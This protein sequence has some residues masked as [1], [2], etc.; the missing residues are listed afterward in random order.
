M[1][2]ETQSIIEPRTSKTPL[3]RNVSFTLMWSSTAASGFGDRM[4]MLAAAALLGISVTGAETSSINAGINFWFMLPYFFLGVFGGWIADTLPR[5]W[6][7]FG[8]DEAR[9]VLL[10]SAVLM[11]PAVGVA[12]IP[13]D[14][15]WRVFAMLFVVGLFAAIFAPTRNATIPQLVPR[16]QLAAANAIIMGIA[17]VFSL[18]GMGI[19]GWMI[20]GNDAGSVRTGLFIGAILYLVSGTFWAFLRPRPHRASVHAESQ[21]SEFRRLGE[22]LSYIWAHKRILRMVLLS[23]LFWAAAYV[24]INSTAAFTSNRWYEEGDNL[25]WLINL[26]GMCLGGGMLVGA[27]AMTFLGT[28]RQAFWFGLLA[29]AASAVAMVLLA[30]CPFYWLATVLCF[31]IGFF[32]NMALVVINTLTQNLSPNYIRGRVFGLRDISD[33]ASNVVINLI[34]WRM[35]HADG[36]MFPTLLATA[37]VL[38]VVALYGLW[39]EMRT[40]ALPTARLN[41]VIRIIALYVYVWHRLE[42]VGKSNIPAT[43][44]VLLCPNHTTGVDPFLLQ[45][46]CPRLIRWLML[47]SYRFKAAEF[48]WEHADPICLDDGASNR[49]QIRAVIDSLNDGKMVGFFPEGSLQREHRELQPFRPGVAV[50]ARRSGAPILPAWIE[51]TPLKR[52]MIWHFLCPSRSRVIFGKPFTPAP[53][54]SDDQIREELR[55]RMLE[56]S[57]RGA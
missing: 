29:L 22:A 16:N 5:K 36:W 30:V 52:G 4:M 14:Y 47:T 50:I 26:L 13:G 17:V 12:A 46:Q 1:A 45:P 42:V 39:R 2:E 24:V 53:E 9:G 31:V 3:W 7:L 56:L 49:T 27:I 35:P 11:A 23:M 8:C 6:V 43:G 57:Q 19:G 33:S 40:G 44:G 34:I 41:V 32:G 38:M 37:G 48:I 54:W 18:L 21:R 10:I 25:I 55:L 51:G 28:R 15:H 20:D